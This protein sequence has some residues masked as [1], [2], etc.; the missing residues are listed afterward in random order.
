MMQFHV[1]DEVC[2]DY[3]KKGVHSAA[4]DEADFND[5]IQGGIAVPEAS[6]IASGGGGAADAAGAGSAGA[7][8]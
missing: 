1:E 3:C 5:S 7:G 8:S 6:P 2:S 4:Q